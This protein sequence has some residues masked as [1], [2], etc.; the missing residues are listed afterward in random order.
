MIKTEHKKIV[1]RGRKI[2]RFYQKHILKSHILR[3]IYSG[4]NTVH[5]IINQIG[6]HFDN[7]D[8][9]YQEL[10]YLKTT[11][12][13]FIH[14]RKNPLTG[15]TI[16]SLTD[17]GL[18]HAKDPYCEVKDKQARQ[19]AEIENR[20]KDILEN[21]DMVKRIAY[22]MARN[23]SIG[24]VT[25]INNQ[26]PSTTIPDIQSPA[27]NVTI[28]T[29]A[30]Q[31]VPNDPIS[32]YEKEYGSMKPTVNITQYKDEFGNPITLDEMVNHKITKKERLAQIKMRKKLAEYYF[33]N[34][35]WIYGGFFTNWGGNFQIVILNNNV[36][37]IISISNPEFKRQ[38]VKQV[39][40]GS[41]GG[42]LKID[43]IDKH[44]IYI[45]GDRLKS[46]FLRF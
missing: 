8:Y 24:G 13:P 26:S 3:A 25:T 45:S 40:S 30:P 18:K 21:N 29:D 11:K 22:D 17:R 10:N 27:I 5:D 41:D 9:M 16:Y 33:N 28:P 1:I 36:M 15:E 7:I 39:L 35:K 42:S 38:H 43:K 23:M 2:N 34:K 32:D 4:H 20:V 46:K 37:D 19:K 6:Y 31:N 12:S 44:G 14:D